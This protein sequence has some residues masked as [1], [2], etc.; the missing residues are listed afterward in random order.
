MT[1]TR[2][3]AKIVQSSVQGIGS[4][5]LWHSGPCKVGDIIDITSFEWPMKAEVVEVITTP[6]RPAHPMTERYTSISTDPM[7][8]SPYSLTFVMDG[9]K[10]RCVC[11][12]EGHE[13]FAKILCTLLNATQEHVEQAMAQLKESNP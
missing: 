2:I 4:V 8:L 11:V 10:T 6:S 13:T 5:E 1:K 3:R 12:G 7:S 9:V